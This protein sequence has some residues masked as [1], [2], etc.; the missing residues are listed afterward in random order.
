MK[1]LPRMTSS[2]ID[3]MKNESDPAEVARMIR[4]FLVET[5]SIS[6]MGSDAAISSAVKDLRD[7]RE[8]I[9]ENKIQA[10]N[11][12][13][14]LVNMINDKIRMMDIEQGGKK[15][16]D[17]LG[18]RIGSSIKNTI[19]DSL[20]DPSRFIDAVYSANPLVGYLPKF[21]KDTASQMRSRNALVSQSIAN[22]KLERES[23]EK[24]YTNAL[25]EEKE[26]KGS[27][28][29]SNEVDSL[30]LPILERIDKNIELM[31]KEWVTIPEDTS[32]EIAKSVNELENTLIKQNEENRQSD[33]RQRRLELSR[34]P[35]EDEHLAA[36]V[37]NN[38]E[39]EEKKKSSKLHLGGLPN[40]MG[41]NRIMGM[42]S[43]MLISPALK[44]V[45]TVGTGL[46]GSIKF[47]LFSINTIFRGLSKVLSVSSKAIKG[48]STLFGSGFAK[49]VSTGFAALGKLG[50]G[51]SSIL[52][53]VKIPGIEKIMGLGKFFVSGRALKLF[54]RANPFIAWAFVLY[55]FVKGFIDAG[56][57]TGKNNE[58]LNLFDKITAG[59]GNIVKKIADLA[60]SVS[61]LLGYDNIFDSKKIFDSIFNMGASIQNFFIGMYNKT[62]D[63]LPDSVLETVGLKKMEYVRKI[64]E[65]VE[66][67]VEA[68][69]P[70]PRPLSYS[71]TAPVVEEKENARSKRRAYIESRIKANQEFEAAEDA[72]YSPKIEPPKQK[73]SE[74]LIQSQLWIEQME[75]LAQKNRELLGDKV[76][77]TVIN[78]PSTVNNVYGGGSAN[79]IT[80]NADSTFRK[81]FGR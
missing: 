72:K 65:P 20:P 69:P 5:I 34:I 80:S 50:T 54:S 14:N 45:K 49:L 32:A 17:S 76:N 60:N 58:D 26:L 78:A 13:K 21:I 27:D 46:V 18:K 81:A 59:V 74:S 53:A 3:R 39:A 56:E 68:T 36:L 16:K 79:I 42:M 75:K 24:E 33:E 61:N 62:L 12:S 31:R 40:Q 28:T 73:N 67:E 48:V 8:S 7:I 63:M 51:L 2:Y 44:L 30:F 29:N 9:A 23:I 70:T 1:K 25:L 77:N 57:L 43:L 15:S 52:K 6:E 55:D 41:L 11:Y 19:R 64:G 37:S 47:V 71:E 66:E 4:D 38:A 10:G 22:A 35:V